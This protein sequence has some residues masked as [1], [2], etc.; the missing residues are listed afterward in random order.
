M[1]ETFHFVALLDLCR[2]QCDHAISLTIESRNLTRA[3]CS[4]RCVVVPWCTHFA[5]AE[6]TECVLFPSVHHCASCANATRCASGCAPRPTFRQNACPPPPVPLPPPPQ[7]PILLSVVPDR[8]AT[9]RDGTVAPPRVPC[10]LD[11]ASTRYGD[12]DELVPGPDG[13]LTIEFALME[14]YAYEASATDANDAFWCDARRQP[15]LL[16]LDVGAPSTLG[17]SLNQSVAHV[18]SI[19]NN[20]V[21]FEVQATANASSTQLFGQTARCDN[22]TYGDG[23]VNVFDVATLLSYLFRDFRYAELD[24]DPRHV[25]TVWP[26]D[27]V[28]DRCHDGATRRQYVEQYTTDVCVDVV[29]ASAS[30]RDHARAEPVVRRPGRG[31]TLRLEGNALVFDQPVYMAFLKVSCGARACLDV[32]RVDNE[33]RFYQHGSNVAVSRA[34]RGDAVEGLRIPLVEG[35]SE[36]EMDF[37][38]TEV[39]L[40]EGERYELTPFLAR[41][42]RPT[43]VA[44]EA[45]PAR[46]VP[47]ARRAWTTVS[48]EGHPSRIH[49]V[50][51]NT[52]ETTMYLSPRPFASVD[53]PDDAQVRITRRCDHPGECAE[54]ALVLPSLSN[55][56][57]MLNGTLEIFQTPFLST[58][59]LDVHMYS[60]GTP[61]LD[62]MFVT[63]NAIDEG[64]ARAPT[65][66]LER[67]GWSFDT[68]TRSPTLARVVVVSFVVTA[69]LCA[70]ALWVRT[71]WT[72]AR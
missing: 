57:A 1:C 12:G 36:L 47:R 50:F 25:R 62:Y 15:L 49:A 54:C 35:V 45:P 48:F 55:D 34:L 27:A 11:F 8:N 38:V 51:L 61:R 53:A 59:A 43:L 4:H 5:Y 52:S 2:C 41:A 6:D 22:R 30:G 13:F 29:D 37:D 20:L 58:C 69:V 56:I 68:T 18:S 70:L 28:V 23:V 65:A 3:Q 66:C 33:T 17:N 9:Q 26:R 63:E 64:R 72:H 21:I 46:D 14:H 7:T 31:M 40:S 60:R 71:L 24:P 10:T 19:A 67:D 39:F 16:C 42:P 32:S 44:R